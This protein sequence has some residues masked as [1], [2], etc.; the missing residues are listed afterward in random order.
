[1]DDDE[2]VVGVGCLENRMR[3]L[4]PGALDLRD[5]PVH[6][7]RRHVHRRIRVDPAVRF[8]DVI[9]IGLVFALG[10]RVLLD[11]HLCPNRVGLLV[12]AE[13]FVKG[14][15]PSL[16]H[17]SGS[18]REIEHEW[19]RFDRGLDH[20]AG[21]RS[22]RIE[23]GLELGCLECDGHREAAIDLVESLDR[24]RVDGG[25]AREDIGRSP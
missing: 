19:I 13:G 15:D 25:G 21:A 1:M 16:G 17:R 14:A 4:E 3:L 6:L 9:R 8:P 7:G 22:S 11:A 5:Q 2:G 20:A 12:P 18:G 24:P 23:D 10:Q